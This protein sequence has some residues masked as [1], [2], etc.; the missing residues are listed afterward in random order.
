MRDL[1]VQVAPESFFAEVCTRLKLDL[2]DGIYTPQ[3]V[4]W[5]MIHQAIH[6]ESLAAAVQTLIEQR[7]EWLGQCKRARE[8]RISSRTGGYATA[9]QRL[10]KQLAVELSG[11]SSQQLH[12]VMRHEGWP[13]LGR[14]V[15]LVDGTSVQLQ[16]RPAI[17]PHY[18]PGRNQHGDNHWPVMRVVMFHDAYT[19]LALPPSWGPMY[20]PQATSEQGLASAMLERLPADAVVLGDIN[21]GIFSFAWAVRQSGRAKVLRLQLSRARKLLGREPVAGPGATGALGA[22]PS[23]AR[24]ASGTSPRRPSRRKG[25]GLSAPGQGR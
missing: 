24:P 17:L 2:N 23:R 10:P 21:F 20:G 7:A 13:E 18:S 16:H 8:G 4:C 11:R 12:A 6:G 5:L 14:P 9:R 15:Y 1:F 25:R 3:V 19:G 22:E